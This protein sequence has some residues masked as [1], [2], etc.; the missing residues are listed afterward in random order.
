MITSQSMTVSQTIQIQASVY[1]VEDMV[2]VKVEIPGMYQHGFY[3]NPQSVIF[4]F[5][6]HQL[7]A[8]FPADALV[9]E[10]QKRGLLKV[11]QEARL[12]K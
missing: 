2:H 6:L 10:I 7:A 11:M 1:V 3:Q 8:D 5:P 12:G 9:T 4:T